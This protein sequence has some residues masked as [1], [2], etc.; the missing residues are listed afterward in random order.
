MCLTLKSKH[1]LPRIALRNIVVYK[2]LLEHRETG[3]HE[4]PYQ[5]VNVTVP[6]TVTSK[7]EK[8]YI[9]IEEGLHSFLN[10]KDAQKNAIEV[11]AFVGNAKCYFPVIVK[12]IIPFGS[13]Y[14]KGQHLNKTSF[15]SNKLKYIE[16]VND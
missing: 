2:W 15:A 10:K 5:R 1:T 13:I 3:K 6:S 14:Y 4:T 9:V 8:D 16:I 12:C 7:I 11:F